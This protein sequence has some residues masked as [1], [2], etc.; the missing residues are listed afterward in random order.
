MPA[1]VRICKS[2]R[3]THA[4]SVV[5]GRVVATASPARSPAKRAL[6]AKPRQ[7]EEGEGLPEADGSDAEE[8]LADKENADPG[9]SNDE[10]YSCKDKATKQ[11]RLRLRRA[12]KTVFTSLGTEGDSIAIVFAV[13]F[14]FWCIVNGAVVTAG[15]TFASL[16][17]AVQQRAIR[18]LQRLVK[19]RPDAG[20]S[21]IRKPPLL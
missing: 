4:D 20:I 16:E 18:Q 2:V 10:A 6:A 5:H 12:V 14:L 19:V 15:K 7:A 21:G 8:D 11:D 17:R 9:Y 1:W 3:L 13:A